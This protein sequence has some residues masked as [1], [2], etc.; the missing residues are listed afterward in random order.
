TKKFKKDY[1]DKHIEIKE[2]QKTIE[3]F[4]QCRQSD[5]LDLISS[6]TVQAG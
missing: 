6:F 4:T 5:Q 1:L 2:Y 3:K